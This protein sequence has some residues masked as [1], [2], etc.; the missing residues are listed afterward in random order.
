MK[1][2]SLAIAALTIV[3][4]HAQ[5][6]PAASPFEDNKDP[7][8]APADPYRESK[9]VPATPAS[10]LNAVIS[11]CYEDFSLPL[12]TAAKLQREQ[13]ADSELYA[14]ITAAVEKQ[15]ARQ[16]TFVMLRGKSG[17]KSVSEGVSEFIYPTEY[18]RPVLP[19]SLGVAISPPEVKDAATPI[20]DATKLKDAPPPDSLTGLRMP[21]IGTAFDTRN[22]GVVFEMETTLSD[23]GKRVDLRCVPEHIDMVG[24]TAWGQD[25]STT[26]MPAFES[27]RINSSTA[28]QINRP[29]LLGTMNRPPNSKV[30]PDSANRVWFAF[31]TITLAKP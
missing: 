15:T 9:A 1:L 14:R 24:R 22:V 28:V 6:K 11:V 31:V 13:L 21:A 10:V 2:K 19:A 12:A 4:L 20:P 5:E 26:E 23:D 8:A 18:E 7:S 27:R 3:S 16:E 25:I 30:D 29:H 17:Q